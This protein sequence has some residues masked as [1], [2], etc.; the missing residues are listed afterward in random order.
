LVRTTSLVT[1]LVIE[2]Q[3]NSSASRKQISR[4]LMKRHMITQLLHR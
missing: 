2:R 3:V 1:S 4:R